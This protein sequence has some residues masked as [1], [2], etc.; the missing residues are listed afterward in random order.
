METYQAQLDD[1]LTTGIQKGASDIHLSAG[2]YPTVR[3]DGMLVPLSDK[4]ILTKQEVEGMAFLLLGKDRKEKFLSEKEA[5]FS[6]QMGQQMR[7]RVNVYQAKGNVAI[8][9]RYITDQIRSM[10]ELHLPDQ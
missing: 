7:F 8:V 1:L 3:I 6:Y 5:D 4:K 10:E 2:Y 9:M